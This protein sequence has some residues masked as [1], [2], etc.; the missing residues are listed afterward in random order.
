MY[1]EEI[2]GKFHILSADTFMGFTV[3]IRRL[4]TVLL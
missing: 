1:K 2:E 4:K 3:E